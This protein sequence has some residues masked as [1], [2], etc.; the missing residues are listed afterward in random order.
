LV[1]LNSLVLGLVDL[2]VISYSV[3]NLN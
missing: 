3:L 1:G 2:G